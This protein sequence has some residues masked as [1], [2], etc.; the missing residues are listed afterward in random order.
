MPITQHHLHNLK[1]QIHVL[2][3]TKTNPLFKERSPS[4][5]TNPL[6]HAWG[7]T[8]GLRTYDPPPRVQ[9]KLQHA[10]VGK[11]AYLPVPRMI[12]RIEKLSKLP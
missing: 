9:G 11:A 1:E 7:R 12:I 6:V 3:K 2:N 4:T 10:L 5:P 8:G